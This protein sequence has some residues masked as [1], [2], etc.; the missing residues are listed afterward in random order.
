MPSR[1]RLWREDLRALADAARAEPGP[2]VLLGDYNAGRDHAPF[3]RVLAAG[4]SDA[5]DL[6]V[7]SPWSGMTWPVGLGPRGRSPVG[8]V[9]RLD[10]VLV[11][12]GSIGVRSCEPVDVPGTD[13]L[14]VLAELVLPAAS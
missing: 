1:V 11:D 2:Q 6:T 13:H 12:S 4:L 3:R 10:H 8:P 14:G 5:A 7:R 9:I